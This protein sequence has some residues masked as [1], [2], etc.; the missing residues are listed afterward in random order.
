MDAAKLDEYR[1]A[2]GELQ[3]AVKELGRDS[4]DWNTAHHNYVNA[5]ERC[6]KARAALYDSD[7]TRPFDAK[8]G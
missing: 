5:K 1:R 3:E 6:E 7:E 8:N 4:S 2:V